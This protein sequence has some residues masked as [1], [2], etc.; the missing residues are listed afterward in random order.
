[1]MKKKSFKL[2]NFTPIFFLSIFIILGLSIGYAAFSTTFAVD[3]S[4][5]VRPISDVRITNVKLSS[6][7]NGGTLNENL[8]YAKHTFYVNGHIPA[9]LG[10]DGNVIVDVTVTNMSSS[11]VII[12]GVDRTS[13]VPNINMNYSLVD[14]VPNETV[15]PPA[16]DYTFK[17]KISFNPGIV[18]RLLQFTETLLE[19]LFGISTNF[20]ETFSVSWSY[21]PQYRLTISATPNDALITVSSGDS[22]IGSSTGY[23]SDLVDANSTINW[24]VSKNGYIPVDGTDLMNEEKTHTVELIQAD[25]HNLTIVPTPSDAIVKIK[26]GNTVLVEAAGSQTVLCY[27]QNDLEYEVYLENYISKK[28]SVTTNGED[29]TLDVS[30]TEAPYFNGTFSNDNSTTPKVIETN[31]YRSGYYMFELWGGSGGNGRYS[32]SNGALTGA[33]G[34]GA[35]SGYTQGIFH[36]D[37]GTLV[38]ISLGG[39]GGTGATASSVTAGGA[40]AGGT[41]SNSGG[42]GGGY[43]FVGIN[44]SSLSLDD[45]LN[46]R[47]VTIAGGGGG[48]GSKIT[49][50]SDSG[51]GG[52]GGIFGTSATTAYDNGVIYNGSNGTTSLTN[53]SYQSYGG[54]NIGGTCNNSTGSSGGLFTGGPGQVL[55]GGGGAG[56]YGG[57][58]GGSRQ[59]TFLSAG[60]GSG[61]SGGSSYINNN[62]IAIGSSYQS[63]ITNTNPS[64]TGGAIVINYLGSTLN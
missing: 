63:L 16:S 31:V 10:A 33:T 35:S 36:L 4:G 61:G 48:G 1:M 8:E 25:S 15:I 27:D 21:V 60:G 42:G 6:T 47:I 5:Y 50:V 56:F 45:L 39:N 7:T 53:G 19:T 52:A 58:G 18:A 29:K 11:S 46:N 59:A 13:L 24:N 12:T 44:T 54:T 14:V 20:N 26:R 34:I 55:G 23:F 2:I 62:V 9:A 32:N 43:S 40:N 41:S 22:I 51:N 38:H 57:A 30:L 49:L 64:S 37:Y 17:V 28:G 3:G